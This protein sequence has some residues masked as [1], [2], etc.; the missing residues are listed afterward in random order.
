MNTRTLVLTPWCQPVKVISWQ[1]A[2]RLQYTEKVNVLEVYAGEELSSPSVTWE[3]PAVVQ[4]RKPMGAMKRGL[5][6]SRINVFTRDSFKCQY[7]GAKGEMKGLTYDHVL[8]R[9]KGGK[10]DWNNI[11][12]SCRPCNDYK[13]NRTPEQA[14]MKLAAKPYKP[15]SLPLNYLQLDR[16]TIPEEWKPYCAFEG[17]VEDTSTVFHL[18]TGSDV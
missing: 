5:K 13:G 4:L 2:V 6:F 12:A 8:P 17:I 3:M 9:S 14:G 11:V 18:M 10:T 7:C 16:K 15:K 1:M